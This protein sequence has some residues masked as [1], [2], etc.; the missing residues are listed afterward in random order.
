[1]GGR[2]SNNG[3][4]GVKIRKNATLFMDGLKKHSWEERQKIGLIG[5]VSAYKSSVFINKQCGNGFSF[6]LV[7]S[8]ENDNACPPHCNLI[9]T[10]NL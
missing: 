4:E 8:R 9:R 5:K 10:I 6:F 3:G 1:M 2:E 7:H